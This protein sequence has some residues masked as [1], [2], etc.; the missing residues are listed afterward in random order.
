MTQSSL[1]T[2]ARIAVIALAWL[3]VP[4][5]CPAWAQERPAPAAEFAAGTLLFADDGIVSE[6]FVGGA[7]RF[8]VL[9]RISVGPE[10]AYISGTNHSHLV[11]TGN[12]TFDFLSP[13]NGRP[14]RATPF[15]VVGGGLFRTRQRFPSDPNFASSEGAFTAGGGFRARIS[16]YVMAGVEARIGWELHL[17]LNATIGVLLG[18]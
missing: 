10:L 16:D 17:R 11:L 7:A 18:R 2:I 12:A 14:R 9:P 4:A 15:A 8:Y 1:C 13:L 6:G 5:S 3:V